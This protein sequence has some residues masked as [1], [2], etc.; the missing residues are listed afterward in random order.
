MKDPRWGIHVLNYQIHRVFSAAGAPLALGSSFVQYRW[1]WMTHL[2]NAEGTRVVK[3]DLQTTGTMSLEYSMFTF[4]RA[5]DPVVV[6]YVLLPSSFLLE[7]GPNL[8]MNNPVSTVQLTE[9]R[10]LETFK[11]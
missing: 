6:G 4:N 9:R 11:W 1:F 3:L 8:H 10:C 2:V 7:L 5:C